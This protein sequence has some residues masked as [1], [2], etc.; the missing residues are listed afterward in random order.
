M[1]KFSYRNSEC[2][3]SGSRNYDGR[4]MLRGRG[5]LLDETGQFGVVLF[6]K[7]A[8]HVCLPGSLDFTSIAPDLDVRAHFPFCWRRSLSRIYKYLLLLRLLAIESEYCILMCVA[9]LYILE[10]TSQGWGTAVKKKRTT[11]LWYQ[12]YWNTREKSRT[13]EPVHFSFTVMI[14][15]RIDQHVAA[16]SF[17]ASKSL[18][19]AEAEKFDYPHFFRN[20]GSSRTKRLCLNLFLERSKLQ[21]FLHTFF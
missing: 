1:I 20:F 11:A 19:V 10:E 13:T 21:D 14:F 7:W 6:Q 3:S 12:Y 16:I 9:D 18:K 8:S 2:L 4:L 5:A 17:I 15:Q